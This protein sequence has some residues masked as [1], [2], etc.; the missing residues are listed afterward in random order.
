MTARYQE[1]TALG[2]K[3]PLIYFRHL[4]VSWVKAHQVSFLFIFISMYP[5]PET[6]I[7][8]KMYQMKGFI[9]M[10]HSLCLCFCFY[11]VG[12]CLVSYIAN[13]HSIYHFCIMIKDFPFSFSRVIIVQDFKNVLFVYKPTF[14]VI[15]C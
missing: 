8:L 7:W 2:L 6:Q 15:F 14:F 5:R 11:Q 12:L 10:E 13:E 9:D 1:I 3:T 4:K